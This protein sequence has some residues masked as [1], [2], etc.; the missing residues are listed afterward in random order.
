M[1]L[2]G[3]L[4]NPRLQV[5]LPPLSGLLAKADAQEWPARPQPPLGFRQGTV[6]NAVT[7]ILR[8]A[9]KPMRARDVRAA[10]ETALGT[11]I[12]ASSVQEALSTHSCKGDLRFHRVAFGVY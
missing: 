6:L 4:S 8:S 1:E 7:G 2:N 12:P 10:V 9:N 3:A 11:A 5:E